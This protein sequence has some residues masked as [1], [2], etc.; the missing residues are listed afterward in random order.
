MIT[1]ADLI[2]SDLYDT[3][4]NADEG[5]EW[6]TYYP[7]DGSDSRRVLALVKEQSAIEATEVLDVEME[8]LSIVVGSDEDHAKGGVTQPV[9][10]PVTVSQTDTLLRDLDTDTRVF[11]FT[12][13]AKRMNGGWIM[14]FQRPRKTAYGRR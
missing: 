4:L 3:L 2:A 12:G 14:Q 10:D 5:A 11:Q 13:E 6:I 7:G 1:L 8:T 9:R